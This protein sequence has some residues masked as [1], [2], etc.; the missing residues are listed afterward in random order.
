MKTA[1]LGSVTGRIEPGKLRPSLLLGG[2]PRHTS[3][4]FERKEDAQAWTD[5]IAKTNRGA[6]RKV[7]LA[8]VS[9][10]LVADSVKLI[11]SSAPCDGHESVIS[12]D[13]HGAYCRKCGETTA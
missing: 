10:V 11:A 8:E 5:T 1:Y 9:T 4:P 2:V 13:G 3:A 7:G 6:G 12:A